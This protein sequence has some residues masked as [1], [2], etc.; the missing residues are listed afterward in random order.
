MKHPFIPNVSPVLPADSRNH[1]ESVSVYVCRVSRFGVCVCLCVREHR[2]VPA[3]RRSCQT[4]AFPFPRKTRATQRDDCFSSRVTNAR[5]SIGSAGGRGI[6]AVVRHLA[7][8][9]IEVIH[10]HPSTLVVSNI[11]KAKNLP[12]GTVGTVVTNCPDEPIPE[13]Q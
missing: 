2:R 5:T 13:L 4:S 1:V 7:N 3:S 10:T 9:L 8:S 12:S 6:L 11:P